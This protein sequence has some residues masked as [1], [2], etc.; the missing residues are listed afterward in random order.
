LNVLTS[1]YGKLKYVLTIL[2]KLGYHKYTCL[3]KLQFYTFKHISNAILNNTLQ[4]KL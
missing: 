2:F 3:M 4:L 1:M